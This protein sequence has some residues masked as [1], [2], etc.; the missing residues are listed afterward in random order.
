MKAHT[1]QELID[2]LGEEGKRCHEMLI[3]AVN[4]GVVV[5]EDDG[6]L[7][8]DYEYPAHNLTRSS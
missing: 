7:S 8:M 6:G 3:E 2:T 5:G 1:T 4:Q